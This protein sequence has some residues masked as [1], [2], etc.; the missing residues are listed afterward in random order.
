MTNYK[1]YTIKNVGEYYEII[2]KDGKWIRNAATV[3]DAK[4]KIDVIDNAKY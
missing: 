3:N 4:E 2:D 1:G